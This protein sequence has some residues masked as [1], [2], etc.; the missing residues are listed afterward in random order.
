MHF[1]FEKMHIALTDSTLILSKSF[2]NTTSSL[3]KET[4]S[5]RTA[6]VVRQAEKKQ[7][8]EN[9]IFIL[10]LLCP[11]NHMEEKITYPI[12]ALFCCLII[13]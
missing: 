2:T 7:G 11:P 3:I 12:P 4:P 5:C 13:S 10:Y 1:F 8:G 9:R 6:I